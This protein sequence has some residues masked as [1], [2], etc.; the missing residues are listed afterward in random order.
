MARAD[1][2]GRLQIRADD[3]SGSEI[4]DLLRLHLAG[5]AAN[6]PPASVFALDLSGLLAPEVQVW[7]AWQGERLAGMGALKSLGNSAGEVK[8][9]RTHPDFLRCGI[10]AALLEHIIDEARRRGMTRLSLETGSG[11]AFMPAIEL[12]RRR[13]FV[14]GEVFGDYPNTEFNRFYHLDLGGGAGAPSDETP[15][16]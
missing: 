14:E 12:Y 7:S 9:M 15:G 8:S 2:T 3:L 11:P 13:G 10:A 1:A 4:Q 6:S 5:V 16:R